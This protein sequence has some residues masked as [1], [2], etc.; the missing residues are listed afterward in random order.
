MAAIFEKLKNHDFLVAVGAIST[1]FGTECSL[2]L[3]NVPN[4][5][6]LKILQST[7]A[8]AAILKN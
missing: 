6:N 3:L 7:I 1:K 2:T 5:K 4:V 8:A